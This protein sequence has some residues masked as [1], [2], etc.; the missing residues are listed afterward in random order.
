MTAANVMSTINPG[1]S[2]ETPISIKVTL[3]DGDSK[4][5]KIAL[6]DLGPHT[7]PEKLRDALSIPVTQDIV[8]ER[9][10]DS[11]GAYITLDSCNP[12]VYKQLYRAAKAKLKLRIK[13]ST[14]NTPPADF[15]MDHSESVLAADCYVPPTVVD[16][17][18][19]AVEVTR[20]ET[21]SDV[22]ASP[23][24]LA[25]AKDEHSGQPFQG[26]LRQAL[27][28]Q[29]KVCPASSPMGP[30][31]AA[32]KPV[33]TSGANTAHE[34]TE[35]E[36]EAS[37]P[38]FFSA[39][40]HLYAELASM[41]RDRYPSRLSADV[42]PLPGGSFTICCNHCDAA[43]PN[44]H[45][46]CSRCDDGDFDLCIDCVNKGVLC[47]SKD[48]WLIKRFVKN[49]KVTYSTT[50]R[51]DPKK[52]RAPK[53]VTADEV[54]R[55]QTP[56]RKVEDHDQPRVETRTCNSCIA[57]FPVEN[58]F[59]CTVCEDYDLC[60]AC[61]IGMKHG[62]HPNHTLAPACKDTFFGPMSSAFCKPGRN[63]RHM[64]ICDGCDKDIYG[65]RHKCL[66]C[67]DWDYCSV[68]IKD[69][70]Q[71]HPGHR[72]INLWEHVPP[73]TQRRQRH[74]G[75]QCDGPLCA[76]KGAQTCIVGDRYK[77]AVCH[78]TDFCAN[79]EALPTNMHNRT[80]PLIKLKTPVRHLGVVAIN[81]TENGDQMVT[82]CDQFQD[83]AFKST[84]TTPPAK[85]ANAATQVNS[86]SMVKATEPINEDAKVE[87]EN[88]SVLELDAYFMRDTVIDGT[89]LPPSTMFTQVWTL[90]NPGPRSWPAGCSVRFIGGT[91]MFNVD[92][93][94]PSSVDD[95]VKAAESNIID[96]VVEVGEQ[97]DFSVTMKTPAD[98]GRAVSYW[99]LKNAK[100]VPF[101]HKIWCDIQVSAPQPIM[102]PEIQTENTGDVSENDKAQANEEELGSQMIFPKL[103]KESPVASTHEAGSGPASATATY[104]ELAD[105]LENLELDSSDENDD[106]FFTDEDYELLDMSDSE[107]CVAPNGR[108]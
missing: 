96:R 108:K 75:V 24:P 6:R 21:S 103:E 87:S 9:F 31:A 104:E 46:H 68:C 26:S 95:L 15:H 74:Y 94:H 44:A 80:H 93:E 77:C 29:C 4:R 71:T 102:D 45:W 32:A 8:L 38:R 23:S 36:D 84:E 51:I 107:T 53:K 35:L 33:G 66:D 92:L 12:S 79:C 101:G 64:A 56:D 37:T 2:P 67:P 106:G 72:F 52:A 28:S 59:T 42:V 14:V 86:I 60:T 50:E 98:M 81:E 25:E 7:L 89:I 54:P 83:T 16:G 78:D 49:G 43:I 19:A 47:D 22:P 1:P 5:V 69:C 61:L 76:G 34:K 48:H 27:P 57:V 70:C 55:A 17:S 11:A 62:H 90:L 88:P 3:G 85:L 100:G 41:S 58:F 40:E 91:T 10:S 97:V 82:V 30:E 18:S 13:V 63:M 73:V 65:I 99:R 39:R 20:A 105:N